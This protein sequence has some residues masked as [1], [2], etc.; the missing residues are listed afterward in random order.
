M[1]ARLAARAGDRGRACAPDARATATARARRCCSASRASET[2]NAPLARARAG[3][4]R[5]LARTPG[6][7]GIAGAGALD[8][9]YQHAVFGNFPLMFAIIAL[10][11]IVLLT[12]AFRSLVLAVKAV[13]AQPRLDGGRVRGDDLVL[14]GGPRL[15][16]GLRDPG[17]GRDHVLDPADDLRVPVRAVDGLRGL[18]P[19]PRAG[20]VRPQRLHRRGGDRRDSGARAAWS[21]APR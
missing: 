5:A 1:R 16:R 6:V 9:D 2:V 17:D 8:L 21:R 20:G 13:A 18:H 10:L 12:R 7:I 14:A 4:A 15:E 19:R 3:G 11:T